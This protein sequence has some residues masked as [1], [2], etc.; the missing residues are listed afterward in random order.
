[1]FRQV[2]TNTEL[3]SDIANDCFSNITGD[4]YRD[5]NSFLATLRALIA[6]RM[7]EDESLYLSY[8]VSTFSKDTVRDHQP[9]NI[10]SSMLNGFNSSFKGRIYINNVASM[11]ETDNTAILEMVKSNFCRAYKG[12]HPL[13]RVTELFKGQFYTLCFVNPELKSVVVFVESLSYS[14]W[15]YLQCAI[16]GFFPWYF[17]PEQGVSQ[18]EMNLINTLRNK[19]DREYLN[20]IKEIAKKYDF[21]AAKI[22]KLLD[23]FENR[24]V[25]VE[26]NSVREQ[27]N[28]KNRD[29]N[30]YQSHINDTLSSKNDLEVRL[31][32]LETKLANNEGNSE[33]MDYFLVNKKLELEYVD[34]RYITFV[35]KDYIAYFDEDVVKRVI[36]NPSSY[37]YRCDYRTERDAYIPDE[38]VK[39]LMYAIFIDQNIKIRVCAAYR[40]NINGGID[41]LSGH[42]F[43]DIQ[44]EY[45][46][47]QHIQDY[48]CMGNYTQAINS[49]LQNHD[50]ISAVEQCIA[51][52]KSLNFTDSTVMNKFMAD[53]Y[54]RRNQNCKWMELPDGS[55][56]TPAQAADWVYEQENTS[57]EENANE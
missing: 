43:G 40:I 14:K 49:A 57:Q 53:F 50:Y 26:I 3:T 39:K 19:D 41:A 25:Q 18:E 51:S 24:Y 32:G 30:S 56:V 13:P 23:G 10:I 55:L 27:I 35:V 45:I 11:S 47:N 52:A 34:G 37:V 48:S 31:L 29:I 22:K 36:D 54:G 1:M 4:R 8:S 5:D 33:I 20:C 38:K 7:S 9:K 12:W 6:P 16:L 46:P 15:H 21:R 2:I 44:R 17:S 42:D 28:R